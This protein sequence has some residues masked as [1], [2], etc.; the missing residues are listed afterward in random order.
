[1]EKNNKVIEVEYDDEDEPRKPDVS[2]SDTT[3]LC[4]KLVKACLQHGTVASR[5]IEFQHW[6]K[7]ILIRGSKDSYMNF[8]GK[9]SA[10]VAS[11][12]SKFQ[13][14]FPL[15]ITEPSIQMYIL[16]PFT[17]SGLGST[18]QRLVLG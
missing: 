10:E 3:N 17:F 13:R 2:R 8:I 16:Y 15:N 11:I 9:K 4:E 5:I 14:I 12:H 7:R 1:M 6:I 18:I